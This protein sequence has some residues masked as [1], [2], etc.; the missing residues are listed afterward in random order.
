MK[1]FLA[2][3][4]VLAMAAH[5]RVHLATLQVVA[6]SGMVLTYS[7]SASLPEAL[8]KTFNGENPCSLCNVVSDAASAPNGELTAP[9]PAQPILLLADWGAAWEYTLRPC[10]AVRLDA[11]LLTGA[12]PLRPPLPPPR[13]LA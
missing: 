1:R 2:I 11:G 13:G 5:A 8:E 3:L 6:W 10:Y 12:E 7:Q 4:L 9:A